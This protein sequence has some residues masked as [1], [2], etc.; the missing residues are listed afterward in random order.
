MSYKANDEAIFKATTYLKNGQYQKSYDLFQKLYNRNKK[1]FDFIHKFAFAAFHSGEKKLAKKLAMQMVKLNP[2]FAI[3]YNI[4]GILAL[5]EKSYEQ[6]VSYFTSCIELEPQNTDAHSNL[7]TAYSYLNEDDK[8]ADL[9]FKACELMPQRCDLLENYAQTLKT[10]G[11]FEQSKETCEKALKLNPYSAESWRILAT[12][13]ALKSSESLHKLE[14]A[15]QNSSNIVDRAKIHFSFAFMFENENDISS[16]FKHFEKG[17][18]LLDSHY[19]FDMAIPKEF[20]NALKTNYQKELMEKFKGCGYKDETPI[21][22]VGMPRSGTT[23]TEQIISGH[24]EVRRGGEFT[25]MDAF[26]TDHGNK[27]N[28]KYPF[29]LNQWRRKDIKEVGKRYLHAVNKLK[30]ES[31][32]I[33]DKMPE[34]FI[35]LGLI[36]SIFPN[37][38]IIHCTRNPIDTCLGNYRQLFQIGNLR[39]TY[40]F[41]N[42]IEYYKEY[43]SLMEHWNNLFGDRILEVNYEELIENPKIKAEQILNH[44]GL[45]WNEQ[46]LQTDKRVGAVKTA[47]STQVREGIHQKNKNRWKKY[48]EFITPLLEEFDS[49]SD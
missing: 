37:A 21:F 42:I 6:A 2:N 40:S 16:A 35:H 15:L 23:L 44:C 49:S 27:I 26:L 31:K 24:P 36:H 3:S 9:Q 19:S 7:A 48:K 20:L 43:L 47:S 39:Y 32:Y 25:Y 13:N 5:E 11:D 29:A 28:R 4:L 33:T 8:T 17:N 34:N 1:S 18:E 22:I 45:E 41:Q 46:C 30:S 14:T 10:L 38:R 12:L